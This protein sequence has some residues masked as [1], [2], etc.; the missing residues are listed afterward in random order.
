MPLVLFFFFS[1]FLSYF[2]LDFF[3]LAD[4]SS[5]F[6]YVK[7]VV[8]NHPKVMPLL[9]IILHEKLKTRFV[10]EGRWKRRWI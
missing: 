3:S 2:F 4:F 5:F 7:R 8:C 6:L 10:M 1:L 9:V